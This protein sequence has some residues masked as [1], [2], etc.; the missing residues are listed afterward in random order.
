MARVVAQSAAAPQEQDRECP[1]WSEEGSHVVCMCACR[2]ILV[3]RR[4]PCRVH[5]CMQSHS[6]QK[7]GAMS[8]AYAEPCRVH[9]CMQSHSGHKKGAS[10]NRPSDYERLESAVYE[11][12]LKGKV[13]VSEAV[14]EEQS[15]GAVSE[16]QRES[17]YESHCMRSN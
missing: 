4:E 14:Y 16:E 8:C 7:K 2:A 9:A 17:V 5:A 15:A 12:H 10:R 1:F 6:G 3:T 11:K 13:S